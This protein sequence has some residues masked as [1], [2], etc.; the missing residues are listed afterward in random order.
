MGIKTP[1]FKK[2][3][4]PPSLSFNSMDTPNFSNLQYSNWRLQNQIHLSQ[5]D[6]QIKE[7]SLTRRQ[8]TGWSA[9]AAH[10]WLWWVLLNWLCC[11]NL[12]D[13]DLLDNTSS[14]LF[15][16]LILFS[17]SLHLTSNSKYWITKLLIPRVKKTIYLSPIKFNINTRAK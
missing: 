6:P 14:Y 11:E 3:P 9:A 10:L 5:Q 1:I 17:K 15:S 12:Y 13:F 2:M 4:S 8:P 7:K 16:C